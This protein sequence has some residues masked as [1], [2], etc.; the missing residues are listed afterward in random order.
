MKINIDPGF[1]YAPYNPFE[2][3]KWQK[4]LMELELNF[5]SRPEIGHVSREGRLA[6][7]NMIMQY[8][9]PGPYRVIEKYLPNRGVFGFSLEF[10]DPKEKTMWLLKW[11]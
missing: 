6:D 8:Q 2:P 9:F 7:V 5:A 4:K 3:V 10:D 1:F 11:S